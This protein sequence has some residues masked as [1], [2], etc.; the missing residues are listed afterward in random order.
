MGIDTYNREAWGTHRAKQPLPKLGSPRV[1][2]MPSYSSANGEM[3]STNFSSD[4]PGGS[5]LTTTYS[6]R[7]IDVKTRLN[8]LL[9]ATTR[10]VCDLDNLGILFAAGNS[11]LTDLVR[12]LATRP[13]VNTV[14][15]LTLP[16]PFGFS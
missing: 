16:F 12:R 2:Y 13:T 14:P 3:I 6:T 7:T 10:N 11:R 4:N 9:T 15:T 1:K 5:R 8:W